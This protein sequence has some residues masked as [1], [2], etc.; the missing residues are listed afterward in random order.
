MRTFFTVVLLG[1]ATLAVA[2][3]RY[4]TVSGRLT[5][6]NGEPL[7]GVNVAVKGTTTGTTTDAYGNYSLEVP[8]GGTVIF[9]FVGMQTREM[10]VT[11]DDMVNVPITETDVRP[12][13]NTKNKS[14]QAPLSV[15]AFTLHADSTAPGVAILNHYTPTYTHTGKEIDADRIRS[16]KPTVASGLKRAKTF[17]VRMAPDIAYSLQFTTAVGIDHITQTP[18][19]QNTYV[20]GQPQGGA[21]QWRGPEYQE[22]FSWGPALS[23]LQYD[24]N[25]YPYDRNGRLVPRGTGNGRA[26]HAYDATQFFRTGVN[27]AYSLNG[28][29]Q[30]SGWGKIVLDANH[31]KQQGVIPNS[32]ST[33][34]R[35]AVQV[36]KIPLL[37]YWTSDANVAYDRSAGTLVNRGGNF[38]SIVGAVWRT[39][40]SF[41]NAD[42]LSPTRATTSMRASRFPTGDVRSAAPGRTDN[43]Y[44]MVRELPD[45]DLTRRLMGGLTIRRDAGKDFSFV[46]QA[47][48]EKQWNEV[49]SGL[50]PGFSG[51][52]GRLM[53]RDEEQ[54]AFHF[55]IAPRYVKQIENHQ[56]EFNITYDHHYQLQELNRLDRWDIPLENWGTSD[57]GRELAALRRSIMRTT[58]ELL[59]STEY[60]AP[61]RAVIVKLANHSYFSNTLTASRYTNFFPSVQAKVLLDQQWSLYPITELV[62]S[63]S[64]AR[65][66]HEAPLIHSNWS[67]LSVT[68]LPSQYNTFYESRELFFNDQLFPEIE[69]KMQASLTFGLSRLFTRVAFNNDIITDF[70]TPRQH[71]YTYEFVNIGRVRNYG[72]TVALKWTGSLSGGSYNIGV[73][74]ARQNS[75]VT[76]LYTPEHYVPTAGFATVAR[77]LADDKPVGAI[78]GTRYQRD[79]SGQRVVG[80]DGFPLVDPTLTMIGN[81]IPDWTGSITAG[82]EWHR[83][84]LDISFD[85]RKGGDVW[86]GTHAAL[87]YYGRSATTGAERSTYRYIFSGVD[88]QGQPNIT[89]V[90]FY[91]P[92]LPLDQ[93]RWVR[94]GFEGVGEDYIEDASW[95][96]L[97]EVRLS[98]RLKPKSLGKVSE[99]KFS[100]MANNLFLITG[101]S[102]VDPSSSLFGY[103]GSTGLDLFNMPAVRSF[104]AKMTIKL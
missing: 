77:V 24:G 86:N 35:I 8:I 64:Y 72:T 81:P 99:I 88:R 97:Q 1:M 67:Y 83:F 82:W 20:Q 71:G 59:F 37:Q 52:A 34:D 30:R 32:E 3:T 16:I 11:D 31:K 29:L 57:Q 89:P 75:I 87:D 92:A 43:P 38:T 15:P 95:I 6:K 93:N 9:A 60:A 48:L 96:R 33:Q 27:T 21:L 102:G 76:D 101:Y 5:D 68:S 61:G 13:K 53:Q 45:R 63:A 39:P 55:T 44:G 56:L 54:T 78:Y 40:L 51:V 85:I 103:A 22:I 50:P 4:R 10:R 46:T 84:A 94:Y 36:K 41:D 49:V 104:T 70:I 28:V 79:A 42:G 2:Q 69:H 80:D 7:P 100:L 62:F 12:A 58:R 91:D 66:L 47:S 73:Q 26:G 23:S 74:W 18:A 90:S 19:L 98:Y 17:R 14:R 65:T 25:D